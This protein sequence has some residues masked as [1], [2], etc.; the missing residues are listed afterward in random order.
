[1]SAKVYISDKDAESEANHT[2]DCKSK[3]SPSPR[4]NSPSS[5][6]G[7][8]VFEDYLEILESD[9][10][11]DAAE[12]NKQDELNKPFDFYDDDEYVFGINL[13]NNNVACVGDNMA[14]LIQMGR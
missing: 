1:M 5:K 7:E 12:A 11:T 3:S 6:A 2:G 8:T 13:L 14:K 4:S 10:A 9:S